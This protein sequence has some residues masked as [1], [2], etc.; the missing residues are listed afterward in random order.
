M[1]YEEDDDCEEEDSIHVVALFHLSRKAV[2][3]LVFKL[4]QGSH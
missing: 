4:L 1:V 3:M 2:M